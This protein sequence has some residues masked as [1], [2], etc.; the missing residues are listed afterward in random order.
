MKMKKPDSAQS[1]PASSPVK[2]PANA[3]A[4][5]HAHGLVSPSLPEKNIQSSDADKDINET[6]LADRDVANTDDMARSMDSE[7]TLNS[8]WSSLQKVQSPALHQTRQFLEIFYQEMLSG[9]GTE[10]HLH[11]SEEKLNKLDAYFKDSR[12]EDEFINLKCEVFLRHLSDAK[13]NMTK[14]DFANRLMKLPASQKI[15]VRD[16]LDNIIANAL[17][18]RSI[19]G[20]LPDLVS[21][22]Q[23][24]LLQLIEE[25]GDTRKEFLESELRP[26]SNQTISDQIKAQAKTDIVSAA[27]SSFIVHENYLSLDVSEIK[28]LLSKKPLNAE[29][30]KKLKTGLKYVAAA[31]EMLFDFRLT[32]G[33]RWDD[34]VLLSPNNWPRSK[35]DYELFQ[36]LLQI[37]EL[38]GPEIDLA[39]L[40]H[41]C[42]RHEKE[43]YFE[44]ADDEAKKRP[45]VAIGGAGPAGL[46]TAI[47]QF[48]QGAR[49]HLFEERDT[50]YD[51]AQVV[52][53]DPLWG[54]T[55][56]FY[57]GEKYFSLFGEKE[58]SGRIAK[59]GFGEI[60]IAD[61]EDAL[62][63][64]F[65]ELNSLV[66][67]DDKLSRLALY[68]LDSLEPP[69]KKGGKY[70]SKA[71][72][73]TGKNK[74]LPDKSTAGNK[75]T[76]EKEIDM[77]ICAGGKNSKLAEKYFNR[78]NGN[79]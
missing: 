53:L 74:H 9:E 67:N 21:R 43:D 38:R 1:Q 49:V 10:E 25:N 37:D 22:E 13:K 78:E 30:E 44:D 70:T 61:L 11:S 23:I 34:S 66:N 20:Y 68:R 12:Q 64:R 50:G 6:K 63:T 79:Q 54:H 41:I 18:H 55:L 45:S 40:D 62:H 76:V 42:E 26:D 15:F 48:H 7:A 46:L 65:S 58:G 72:F 47:T 51:R 56:K 29:E 75:K 77:L 57:L 52:R 60:V 28:T 17:T 33:R 24:A 35:Q 27:R 73:D 3:G 32:A 31:R 16:I 8:E 39:Q 59:D 71:V 2:T 19:D 69:M 5:K 4:G 36:K 14:A